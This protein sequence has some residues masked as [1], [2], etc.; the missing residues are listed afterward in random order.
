MNLHAY[1]LTEST[2]VSYI[3][4]VHV[5]K[6]WYNDNATHQWTCECLTQLFGKN[7]YEINV[8]INTQLKTF[9]F[10]YLTIIIRNDDQTY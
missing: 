8:S 9:R 5:N 4:F 10:T 7:G 2:N 3:T 1:Q 6:E